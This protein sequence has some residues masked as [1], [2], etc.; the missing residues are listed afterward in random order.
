M[1]HIVG[2]SGGIDSQAT[3]LW[4][5]R[6]FPAEDVILCN[7]DPGGNEARATV[8]FI[9]EYSETVHPVVKITPIV[10]DLV[11]RSAK[12]TK[13]LGLNPDDPLTFLLL[14]KLK[15]CFPSRKKQFCT[16][17]LKLKPIHRW[18]YANGAR[19]LNPKRRKQIKGQGWVECDGVYGPTPHVDGILS[20]GFE[21]Y[22]GVR[23]DESDAR[24]NVSDR[25]FDDLFMCWLNR[26]VASWTKEQCFQYVKDAG[27]KWNP[28]YDQGFSRVGCFP[29]INSS[30]EEIRLW[31]A[32]YPAE[33][34]KIRYW[35]TEVGTTFFPPVMPPKQTGGK[36]RY[37]RIDEVIEWANTAHGGKQKTIDFVILESQAGMCQNKYG[38]CE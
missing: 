20:G 32:L 16:E 27:E 36:R 25:E 15:K 37:G 14:V 31:A 1:K 11:G 30:K 2:F 34:E 17:H 8:E 4:V 28:L 3:A 18:C 7:A 21:R 24:A 13:E 9:D 35:E 22:A 33:V 10:A 23:R 29:C 26:P 38:M 12:R 6:N 5:R 19:G